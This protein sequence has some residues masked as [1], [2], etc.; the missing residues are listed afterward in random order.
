MEPVWNEPDS[1][2]SILSS[3]NSINFILY[4]KLSILSFADEYF[5]KLFQAHVDSPSI[6]IEPLTSCDELTKCISSFFKSNPLPLTYSVKS[7]VDDE[8][9]LATKSS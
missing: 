6:K 4:I 9:P 5:T 3:W 2:F 8:E 1:N 7:F